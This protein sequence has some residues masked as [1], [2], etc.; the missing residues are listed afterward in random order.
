MRVSTTERLLA[1]VAERAIEHEGIEAV[2]LFGSRARGTATR[3]S[4]WDICVVGERE[5]DDL[6]GIMA[7]DTGGE[8]RIDIIWRTMRA[9]REETHEGTVWADVVHHGHVLAGMPALL[10][11]IEVKPMKRGDIIQSFTVALGEIQTT[12]LS[13]IRVARAAGAVKDLRRVETTRASAAAAEHLSRAMLGLVGAQPGQGHDVRRNAEIVS[14]LARREPD[15]STQR[16]LKEMSAQ[17]LSMN[18]GTHGAHAAPYTGDSETLSRSYQRVFQAMETCAMV[19]EGGLCGTGRLKGLGQ[20]REATRIAGILEEVASIARQITG[21]I[22]AETT[23]QLSDD[24]SQALKR[25]SERCD[26]AYAATR[27]IAAES[28][29]ERSA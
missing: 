18:G 5:P 14:R 28:T 24:A 2:V 7:I 10:E 20:H 23:G 19:L 15:V 9:L 13:A 6:E 26:R 27:R 22:R 21:E 4:D 3:T 16:M 25:W 11:G 29:I 17:I 8:E 1:D 12:L